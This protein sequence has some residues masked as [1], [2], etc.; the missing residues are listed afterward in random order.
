[1]IT[2]VVRT[3]IPW[4]P[5]IVRGSRGRQRQVEAA[6]DTGFSG[7]LMLPAALIESLQLPWVTTIPGT[8][9]DG[10]QSVF[11]VYEA[12]IVWD[13]RERSVAAVKSDADSLVGMELLSGFELKMQVRNQGKVTIKRLK[14]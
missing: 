11:A 4:I 6:L 1:M 10:S 5:L 8:L 7:A 3:Q 12:T 9:A 14:S 2:G 13:R